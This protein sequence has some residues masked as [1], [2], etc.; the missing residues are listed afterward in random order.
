MVGHILKKDIGLLWPL[1]LLVVAIHVCAE[2]PQHLLDM[3]EQ[4]RQLALIA[5]LLAMLGLLG[6]MVVVVLAMHQDAVP[7]VRQDWLTRPIR[8]GDLILAKLAFVILMV[9]AP[10]WLVNVAAA[11]ADGLP[12]SAA[13]VGA[14]T[15]NLAVFCEIALPAMIVGAIT[16]SFI[17]AFVLAIATLAFYVALFQVLLALLLGVRAAVPET[18]AGWMLDAGFYLIAIVVAAAVLCIQYLRR[19]TLLAR[20]LAVLGGVG[21]GACAFAPWHLAFA[22]QRALS[23]QPLAAQSV[24]LGFDAQGGRYQAPRGAAPAVRTAL[25]VPLHAAGVPEGT[26]VLMDHADLR[27]TGLDGSILYRGKSNISVDGV[28]S[29]FDAIFEIRSSESSERAAPLYQRLYLPAQVLKSLGNRPVRITIDESLTLF[30]PAEKYSLPAVGADLTLGA[31][32]RCRTRIDSE[33]DDVQIQC[34]STAKQPL[35]YTAYLEQ[36]GSGLRNPPSHGCFPAY[37]PAIFAPLLPDAIHRTGGELPFFDRSE[38]AQYP[39]D[40]SKLADSRMVIQTFVPA[41]HFTRQV[42]TP[43]VKLADLSTLTSSLPDPEP[44]KVY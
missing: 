11:L 39:I 36:P 37:A 9:Q 32:G 23:P 13:C 38:L 25:Y 40:G 10:L 35:C 43:I 44:R 27:V 19:R 21:I 28:G 17:E 1:A 29:L 5:E 22:L 30:V 26:S 15:R 33:G 7:G 4:S 14:A 20:V 12:L 18:G 3:G 42:E 34:L 41:D 2:V 8:R 6:V 16:R 31:L 24:Q